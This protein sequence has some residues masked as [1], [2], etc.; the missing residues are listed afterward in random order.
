M[1]GKVRE[2]VAIATMTTM[3]TTI[4]IPTEVAGSIENRIKMKNRM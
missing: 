1:G 4:V 2:I 3:T